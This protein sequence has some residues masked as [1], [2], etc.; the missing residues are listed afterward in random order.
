MR[1]FCYDDYSIGLTVVSE[2]DIRESYYPFWYEKMCKKYG[3]EKVDKFYSFQECLE[4]WIV[5]N[6]A[7]ESF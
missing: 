4:D 2:N 5:L 1:Y 6:E 3:K 7:W